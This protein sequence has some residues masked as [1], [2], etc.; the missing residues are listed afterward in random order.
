MASMVRER[1]LI[2]SW[3]LGIA[4][5]GKSDGSMHNRDAD[6]FRGDHHRH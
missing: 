5:I 3:E 1:Q 6:C 4:G 2:Y